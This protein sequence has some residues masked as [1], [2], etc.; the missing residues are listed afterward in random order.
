[1]KNKYLLACLLPL[2]VLVAAR[3]PYAPDPLP[4]RYP[5]GWPAPV[6]AFDK[7]PLTREGVALG[8]RLFYDPVLS[9]DSSI[10]CSNCHL[11][12][13][14]FTHVDHAL[15]HGIGDSIGLRNSATLVNLAWSRSFMWDGAANHL[16]VQAL[17]P[18]S[19]PDE[20]GENFA[21]VVKKVQRSRA[22]RGLFY[23]AFGDSNATGQH[24]LQAL[25]QFQ[26][27]FVSAN[28]RYDRVMRGE[29]G[30]AF[31]EQE[32][33]G[34]AL[35]RT[36]CGSCHQEPLFT[37]GDF[38]RN[39]LPPDSLLKDMGRMRITGN[40]EDSLKFKIPTLRNIEFSYPYMHD[41]RFSSLQQV[42][43]HYAQRIPLSPDERT[44]L[45]AFLL[46]LS[47]KEFLFN[48]NLSYPRK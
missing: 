12:Y 33:K 45:M 43:R 28:A 9:G 22:Y 39:G 3:L 10:S 6:Y 7:N 19:D 29:A 20:M 18:I 32:Q 21:H 5:E 17:A 2:L 15:S 16:D 13:T 14:A 44:D 24:L 36:H 37:S 31:S 8:R 11:S 35:F 48:P 1:M 41:G 26:L 4:F 27:T 23:Q 30:A 38:A 34:Y 25:A 47:D 40:P 46:T 42:L